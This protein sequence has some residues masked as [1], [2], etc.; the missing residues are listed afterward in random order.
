MRDSLR[1]ALLL[2]CIFA[3]APSAAAPG[4]RPESVVADLQKVL[5]ENYVLPEKRPLFDAMLDRNLRSGRYSVTSSQVLADRLNEDLQSVARDK[6]LAVRFD[7]ARTRRLIADRAGKDAAADEGPGPAEIADSVRDHFGIHRLEVLPGNI[8]YLKYDA[9]DWV[10]DPSARALD[11]AIEFLGAGDAIVIDLRENGG[12]SPAAVRY[13]ASAFTDP[14]RRLT[15][16]YMGNNPPIAN[17]ALTDGP[18]GR[19][20]GKPLYV[21]TSNGTASAAEG[22][23][24]AI[25]G[26]RLG[27]IVGQ[28][29]AGAGYR[30][31][32]FPLGDGFFA[33]ISIG[34]AVLVSTGKDWEGVGIAPTIPVDPSKALDVA[35]ERARTSG[36]TGKR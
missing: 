33:S 23:T 27:E 15:T 16:F 13:L 4:F 31:D 9:F 24:G 21:L 5:R 6:H 19:L 35:L 12:G 11:R 28:N 22:F 1:T 29:T 36:S 10:G 26:Y 30:N 3:A 34:R 17:D 25:A 8:R 2:F 14:G 18:A 20:K 7:P 32:L